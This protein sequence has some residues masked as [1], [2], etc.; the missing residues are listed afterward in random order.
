MKI[1]KCNFARDDFRPGFYPILTSPTYASKAQASCHLI[2]MFCSIV[3][4]L[5]CLYR[6]DCSRSSKLPSV[7]YC[8]YYL[9][10]KRH[11]L[12]FPSIFFL[13]LFTH[14]GGSMS[15]N[16]ARFFLILFFLFIFVLCHDFACK[17]M[18]D[19]LV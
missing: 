19:A 5:L 3:T 13:V 14:A 10:A 17:L 15:C 11:E 6:T 12:R 7:F 18:H 9:C 8:Y 2:A 4:T 1:G 16:L